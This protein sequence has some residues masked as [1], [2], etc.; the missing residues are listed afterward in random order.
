MLIGGDFNKK[1]ELLLIE[2]G[3]LSGDEAGTDISVELL[4]KDLEFDRNEIRSYFEYLSDKK[5]IRLR[6]IGGP[7]LYG[8]ISLTKKGIA[9][10]K[11]IREKRARS[12]GA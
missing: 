11:D 3:N 7:F 9:K 5:M 12:S 2:A 4:N 8:H 1:C 6:T 10:L